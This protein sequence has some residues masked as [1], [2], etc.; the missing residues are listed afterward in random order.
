[1]QFDLIA[2]DADDTLWQNEIYYR[3]GRDAF[4]ALMAKYGFPDP[5]KVRLHEIEISNL[6]FYGYGAVG[7]AISIAE[8]AVELTSGEI[9]A[10]D[11]LKLLAISKDIISAEVEIYDG[12][13]ET[14]RALADYH[15]LMLITKGDRNHQESKITRSGLKGYFEQIEIV[16]EKSPDTYQGI[17]EMYDILPER[18]I[19]VGN[20][21][22]SDIL[23]VLEIGGNAVYIHNDLTWAHE[24][25]V[26]HELPEERFFEIDSISDL[27]DLIRQLEVE[28]PT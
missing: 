20:A 28:N 8:A 26:Q 19:M 2:L 14:L 25:T 13:E 18:F 10:A 5:D 21:M 7:F 22:K 17:L 12:V 1:M 23:P 11:L 15:P 4:N 16:P 3:R 24:H 6:E 27:P 9:E